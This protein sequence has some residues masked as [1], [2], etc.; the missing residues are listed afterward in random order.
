MSKPSNL[1]DEEALIQGCMDGREDARKA[2]FQQYGPKML[3]ICSRYCRNIEDARDALQ[4]GFVK[5][6]TQ[7][8]KFSRQSR[9]ETWMTRIMINT[10]IDQFKSGLRYQLEEEH[11]FV[12]EETEDSLMDKEVLITADAGYLLKFLLALPEGYRTIFNLYAIEGFT[13]REIAEIL[14]ISEGTSKSQYAR[15]KAH[16]Q[17]MLITAGIHG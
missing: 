8:G 6:Y 17:N 3:G 4:D 11:H 9:L 13:H 5:I 15:A 2:L 14:G 7:I 1:T 10:A 16:L 12:K